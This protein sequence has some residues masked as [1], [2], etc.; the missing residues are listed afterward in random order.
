MGELNQIKADVIIVGGGLV[1]LAS[2]L[3]LAGTNGGL[4]L[5][6]VIVDTQ[7][8]D[9]TVT[10]E[11]DGRASAI[12]KASRNML[13]AI[14]AWAELEQHA[15]PIS[16]IVVTDSEL[17]DTVRPT[18]L[19]FDQQDNEKWPTA[20]MLENRFIRQALLAQVKKTKTITFFAPHKVTDMTVGPHI[21]E[22]TLDDNRVLSTPLVIAADGRNSYLRQQAGIKTI[23]WEYGQHG[24]V[25]TIEHEHP[26]GGVA[27]EHFLPVGP[28]AILPLKNPCRSSLVWTERDD[29]ARE[30]MGMS[31]AEFDRELGVR[32][33][34]HLGA[35][36]RIGP[37]WSYPLSMQ[38]AADYVAPRLMLVGD[39]AHVVHPLAGLG[40]NLGLRD[41][42]ALVDVVRDALHLGLDYGTVDVGENYQQ[43]RRFDNV[44]AAFMMEAL[45]RLFSNAS[46]TVRQLRDLG[47]SLVEKS[48][49][50][51][52]FFIEE[53]AGLS[54]DLP[55][56][57]RN[58]DIV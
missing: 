32:F 23:G 30:L 31:D 4:G 22:V 21:A 1:G 56:L 2:A 40:F 8:L 11:F 24:I 7:V 41:A 52:R 35:V 39:A 12:S 25:A 19:R 45:N 55:R 15:Q 49:M 14:G 58:P 37:R 53:A 16:D 9:Y 44:S 51:K 43:W 48:P 36:K 34:S 5:K 17:Q 18:F 46:P 47:L 20:F 10:P 13:E 38:L 54:G 6:V 50:A 3:G 29:I 42:A 57:M 26:H 33:G 28:F 27:E